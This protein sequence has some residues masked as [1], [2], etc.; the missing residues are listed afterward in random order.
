MSV[1][2]GVYKQLRIKKETT[3]GT[4]PG[5]TGAQLLRR[6]SSSLDLQKAQITS[7][8]IISTQQIVDMRH[9]ARTVT[10]TIDG[11]LSPKTYQWPMQS[12]L[13]RDFTAVS[14]LT[15]LTLTVDGTAATPTATI[16]QG[17][18]TFLSAGLKVGMVIQ[19]TAGLANAANINRNL[20]IVSMTSSVLTVIPV[21][22]GAAQVPM[23]DEG[24]TGSCTIHVPGMVTYT[25]T[26]GH[27]KDSYSI[28]HWYSD[29]A[30]S[31]RFVGCRVGSM[32]LNLP[33]TGMSTVQFG[34][35]GMNMLTGT[36][37]YFTTPTAPTST[38]VMESV[39]GV[40]VANGTMVGNI[41]GLTINCDG[42]LSTA[43]VVGS[44]FSPDVFVG[45]IRVTGQ[46]T[47]LFNDVVMRDAFKDETDIGISAV[48]AA[49]GT[50][51]SKFM[52]FSMPKVKVG[53]ATKADSEGGL[54]LT[55][56]FQAVYDGTGGTGADTEATTLWVQD[57]DAA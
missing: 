57:S 48:F 26:T 5:A 11:E 9:G 3:L 55:C 10:G 37:E 40:L 18:T 32:N 8:E 39:N 42:G 29:L 14:D 22:W 34:F 17:G 12:F 16:T 38:P 23:V 52:C 20:F 44:N 2:L 21:N 7:N 50:N 30:Q 56:P 28:E 47:A 49:D 27:T 35:L 4:L 31:E 43:T 13:R 24:P 53:G 36:S 45:R 25:P 6:V 1:A 41:T 19:I 46:M 54:V 51:T 33:P 15:S